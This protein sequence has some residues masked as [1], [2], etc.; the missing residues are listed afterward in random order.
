MESGQVFQSGQIRL[1]RVH[2]PLEHIGSRLY[3]VRLALSE[4]VVR[5]FGTLSTHKLR[6]KKQAQIS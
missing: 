1:K 3:R 6:S 5:K 4:S 2:T